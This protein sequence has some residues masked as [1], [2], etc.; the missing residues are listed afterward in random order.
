ML[1]SLRDPAR[2]PTCIQA[3]AVNASA[4]ALCLYNIQELRSLHPCICALA[5]WNLTPEAHRAK[6][7]IVEIATIPMVMTN[8]CKFCFN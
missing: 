1:P 8:T 2:G 3:A 7:A 6:I 5:F 4:H